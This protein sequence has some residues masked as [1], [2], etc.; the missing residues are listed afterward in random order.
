MN[1]F[2]FDETSDLLSLKRVKTADICDSSVVKENKN[3]WEKA[4]QQFCKIT[5]C[6]VDKVHDCMHRFGDTHKYST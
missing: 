1:E 6:L 3:T 2:F 4:L 5:H